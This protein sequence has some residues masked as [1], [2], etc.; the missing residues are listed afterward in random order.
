VG[1][2]GE[3]ESYGQIKGR[4]M[5]CPQCGSENPADSKFCRQC[6]KSLLLVSAAASFAP[7]P[8][9]VH[10]AGFWLRVV[11]HIIDKLVLAIP[12]VI[13]S[14]WS[15]SRIFS[16]HWEDLENV[17]SVEDLAP[18]LGL[19]S[20]IVVTAVVQMLFNWL[21]F[22]MM[23][24]STKQATLGKLAVGIRVTTLDGNRITFMRATGRYAGKILSG[25][26]LGVGFM[27]AGLSTRKQAL[28]DM[29]ADTL[30]VRNY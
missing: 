12:G 4:F 5:F 22:A 18:L 20:T 26:I 3:N 17:E 24:S 25:L 23:E 16:V 2:P 7:P 30:V 28:H 9:P 8:P 29:L 6:G 10:Y 1:E 15:V 13:L 27:M 14:L 21:Y 19:V 11:A